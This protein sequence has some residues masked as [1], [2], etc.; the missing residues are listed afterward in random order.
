M[1]NRKA[2]VTGGAGFLG[3]HL[4]K[5]LLDKGSNTTAP[6]MKATGAMSTPSVFEHATMKGKEFP[7]HCSLPVK[8][9]TRST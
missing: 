6:R 4:C 9:E 3:S 1:K 7:R 5:A 2:L 8:K